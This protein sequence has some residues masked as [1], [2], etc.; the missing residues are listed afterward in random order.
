MKQKDLKNFAKFTGK[1]LR[2]SLFF[3]KVAGLLK[4][5]LRHRCFPANFAKL[6][7]AAFLKNISEQNVIK[8]VLKN[9]KIYRKTT[10]P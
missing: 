5:G 3:N 10:V 2:K 8:S 7:K 6:L 4:K 1:N 9:C